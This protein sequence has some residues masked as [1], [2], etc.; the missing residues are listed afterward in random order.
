MLKRVAR[1]G[2]G[3]ASRSVSVEGWGEEKRTDLG[4]L[5]EGLVDLASAKSAARAGSL[6]VVVVADVAEKPWNWEVR[7]S[8]CFWRV[9]RESVMVRA[10]LG[11]C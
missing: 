3:P 9:G 8:Y 6:G 10:L 2:S 4:F 1:E 7:A 11:V 5:E